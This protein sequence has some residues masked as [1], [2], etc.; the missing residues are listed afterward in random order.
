MRAA[1]QAARTRRGEGTTTR[2]GG[3]LYQFCCPSCESRLAERYEQLQP[4]YD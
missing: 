2:I 1:R 3:E 4:G